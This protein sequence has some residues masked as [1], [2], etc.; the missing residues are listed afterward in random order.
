MVMK[1]TIRGRIFPKGGGDDAEHPSSIPMDTPSSPQ[2]LK[3]PMT[4]ARARAIEHE[5]NSLLFEFRLDSHEDWVLPHKEM[6]CILSYQG[7]DPVDAK[8]NPFSPD[9]V[10]ANEDMLDPELA[11]LPLRQAVLP[12]LDSPAPAVLPPLKRYYRPTSGTTA[13]KR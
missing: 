13:C 3:G 4:R 9:R 5:V 10:E 12:H 1:T 7:G 2:A 8:E 6:L 11:V